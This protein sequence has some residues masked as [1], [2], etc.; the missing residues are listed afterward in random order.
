MQQNELEEVLNDLI[1]LERDLVYSI[2]Q[3]QEIR[4]KLAAKQDDSLYQLLFDV[5][6]ERR[7][8]DGI[9]QVEV[10][11]WLKKQ[12]ELYPALKHECVERGWSDEVRNNRFWRNFWSWLSSIEGVKREKQGSL[13]KFM[14]ISR[15]YPEKVDAE[16][17]RRIDELGKL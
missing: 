6:F 14:G 3:V 13:F 5:L 17:I 16:I 10:F 12:L 2:Q 15:R 11:R 8:D 1:R 7:Y 4:R 9:M